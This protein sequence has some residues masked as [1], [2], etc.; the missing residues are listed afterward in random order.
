MSIIYMDVDQCR[1]ARRQ[2]ADTKSDLET[3]ANQVLNQGETIVGYSWR[4]Q[5]A[6]HYLTELINWKA[7][8]IKLLKRLDSLEGKLDKEIE[9]WIRVANDF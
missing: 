1:S 2:I 9:E 3:Y 5:G 6:N 7:G 4:A 8:I